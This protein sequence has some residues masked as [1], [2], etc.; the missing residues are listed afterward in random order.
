MRPEIVISSVVVLWFVILGCQEDTLCQWKK[1]EK[2]DFQERQ[3]AIYDCSPDQQVDLFLRATFENAPPD[4]EKLSEPLASL[5][6]HVAPAI[7]ARIERLETSEQYQTLELLFVLLRMEHGGYFAVS[8]DD[9]LMQRLDTA[10]S[11]LH[12]PAVKDAAEGIVRWIRDPRSPPSSEVTT[13]R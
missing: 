7:V 4:V 3:R 5:G 6:E 10:I 9:G 1:F 12:E 11:R 2:L 13:G 8:R